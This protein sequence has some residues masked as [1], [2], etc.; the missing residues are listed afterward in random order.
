MKEKRKRNVDVYVQHSV[1]H[2]HCT[3]IVLVNAEFCY[4]LLFI[5]VLV[6][7]YTFQL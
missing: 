1:T 3:I 6:L 7:K 5:N 4:L 2:T